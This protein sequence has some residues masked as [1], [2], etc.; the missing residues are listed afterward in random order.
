MII[1]TTISF[2]G[3]PRINAIKI[4]PSSPINCP[5]GSRNVVQCAS[6]V[7]SFTCVF[8]MNHIIRPAGADIITARSNSFKVLSKTERTNTSFSFGILYGGISKTKV[9]GVPF[10]NVVESIFET[11]SVSK[12]DIKITKPSKIVETTEDAKGSV[13]T[14][15]NIT[16][17]AMIVGNL[18][19][20]GVN[21]FVRIAINF[22]FGELIIRQPIMAAALQPKPMQ[23]V[24]DCFPQQP[25]RLNMPSRLNATRGR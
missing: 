24:K 11:A 20:H 8:A 1:G 6:R 10:N 12:T 4:T 15:K 17:I 3:K 14:A 25:A 16:R 2:A 23:A 5:K 7:M 22:S 21:T 9:E 18:P 19:L 13:P